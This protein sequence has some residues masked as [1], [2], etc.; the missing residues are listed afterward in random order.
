MRLKNRVTKRAKILVKKRATPS[1][2]E[3]LAKSKMPKWRVADE[4]AQ[5]QDRPADSE[6]DAVSPKLSNRRA[7]GT[8]AGARKL[9][10]TLNKAV[11]NSESKSNQETKKSGLVNMVPE[12]EEDAGLGAKTQVFE[13]DEHTGAQ[14]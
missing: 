10:A 9:L 11:S 13:D 14:G 1:S 3:E 6:V 2:L 12:S 5:E 7:A 8:A 4:R